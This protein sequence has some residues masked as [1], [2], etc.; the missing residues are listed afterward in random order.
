[1][2]LNIVVSQIAFSMVAFNMYAT[3]IVGL[4]LKQDSIRK[5]Y[6]LSLSTQ[7]IAFICPLHI[8]SQNIMLRKYSSLLSF[9]KYLQKV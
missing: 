5:Q 6:I 4:V 2:L 7:V 8:T 3:I 9:N 1:M